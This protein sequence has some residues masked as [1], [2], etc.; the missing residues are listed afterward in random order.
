MFGD[1]KEEEKKKLVKL[2]LGFKQTQE[3]RR[4][5]RPSVFRSD[6]QTLE[7]RALALFW[8]ILQ[9]ISKGGDAQRLQRYHT[10]GSC[11]G[12]LE[13]C[14]DSSVRFGAAFLFELL[15]FCSSHSTLGILKL[16]LRNELT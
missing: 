7:L 6:P 10:G 8:M 16:F 12:R 5:W 11:C 4:R 1:Q 2:G 13:R 3:A 15:R 14:R 9:L